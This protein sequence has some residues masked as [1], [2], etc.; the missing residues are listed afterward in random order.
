M[1]DFEANQGNG[2]GRIFLLIFRL[3]KWL[4]GSSALIRTFG[5][6]V[7]YF[8]KIVS[9]FGF[10][11]DFPLTISLG[12]SAKIVHIH[13]LV[14]NKRTVIGEG[15]ILRNGV[16]LGVKGNGMAGAPVIG[17]HVEFGSN[18]IVIGPVHIGSGAKIGAGAVVL[19]DVPPNAIAVGNPARI[20]T[21]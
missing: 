18:A 19:R 12:K 3:A 15:V 16:T 6:P 14:V 1:Q 20:L 8:Y 10:G 7:I 5:I 21:R 11:C 2:K 4:D 13:G 17:D 9:Q